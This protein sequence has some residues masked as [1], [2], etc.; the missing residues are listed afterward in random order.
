MHG[1][2]NPRAET[3][4]HVVHG[5]PVLFSAE[6]GEEV[7]LAA[8]AGDHVFVPPHTPHR[9]ENPTDEEAVVAIARSSQEAIN[10]ERI[11]GSGSSARCGGAA[12]PRTRQAGSA[13][14]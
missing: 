9:E 14:R 11:A 5:N 7:Q 1:A 4:I 3:A 8:E 13:G 6:N 10:D 12:R 2:G